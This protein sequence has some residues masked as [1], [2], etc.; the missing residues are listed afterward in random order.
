MIYN[1]A[2]LRGPRSKTV[3]KHER[4]K[5]KDSGRKY[6]ELKKIYLCGFLFPTADTVLW[7]VIRVGPEA[8]RNPSPDTWLCFSAAETRFQ[9][10]PVTPF[11]CPC[12]RFALVP[13]R[14]RYANEIVQNE[15]LSLPFQWS[16][17]ACRIFSAV[18]A[19]FGLPSAS[20]SVSRRQYFSWWLKKK[21]K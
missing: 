16:Y 15:I 14:V 19:M 10:L 5:I 12:V 1:I 13:P 20:L 18:D 21:K 11:R 7:G 8:R 6:V 3:I 9:S 17:E 4:L 2:L